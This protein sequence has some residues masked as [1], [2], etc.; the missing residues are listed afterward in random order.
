M[1]LDE[2]ESKT[3]YNGFEPVVS[4]S[5]A[6]GRKNLSY[7][8]GQASHLNGATRPKLTAMTTV[9]NTRRENTK[10]IAQ[11]LSEE[12]TTIGTSVNFNSIPIIKY[13]EWSQVEKPVN[14]NSTSKLEIVAQKSLDQFRDSSKTVEQKS[15]LVPESLDQ[16]S[17]SVV[18][19]GQNSN[20]INEMKDEL[21]TTVS[22][23]AVKDNEL[24]TSN[25][26]AD[27]VDLDSLR[28]KV[29]SNCK[30]TRF[31]MAQY[32]WVL[33]RAC[34]ANHSLL[35]EFRLT[36]SI[37]TER[38]M[39]IEISPPSCAH[40]VDFKIGMISNPNTCVPSLAVQQMKMEK[41]KVKLNS[42]KANVKPRCNVIKL[43]LVELALDSQLNSTFRFFASSEELAKEAAIAKY[44]QLKLQ[45]SQLPE[46]LLWNFILQDVKKTPLI[47]F[48]CH[49]PLLDIRDVT[50]SPRYLHCGSEIDCFTLWEARNRKLRWQADDLEQEL[51][52]VRK[53]TKRNLVVIRDLGSVANM[54]ANGFVASVASWKALRELSRHV[55]VNSIGLSCTEDSE[56]RRLQ[57]EVTIN[58]IYVFKERNIRVLANK[59][60]RLM[61]KIE[62][63]G[64]EDVIPYEQRNDTKLLI[65]LFELKTGLS[66]QKI[67]IKFKFEIET[68]SWKGHITV[69]GVSCETDS[70][71]KTHKEALNCLLLKYL[72]DKQSCLLIEV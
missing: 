39:K 53:A 9:Q 21:S 35:R 63:R 55:F 44:L 20:A 16:T 31:Q 11:K 15:N 56:T 7:S 67:A 51:K 1:N 41:P 19:R 13:A 58:D 49:K 50:C 60:T 5:W 59:A 57:F 40:N 8:T 38:F 61:Q 68:I 14:A 6:D 42:K 71:Q 4:Y 64:C 36:D 70:S 25:E 10:A 48:R 52:F 18:A 23:N 45:N 34:L 54:S 29:K 3:V 62:N 30:L 12:K 46:K 26:G 65:S 32:A 27:D 47:L 33:N 37:T 2:F 72:M 43:F 28:Q 66:I 69:D 24:L 22:V 17:L